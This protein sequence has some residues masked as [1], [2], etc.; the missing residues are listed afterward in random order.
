MGD[1][2]LVSKLY[3]NGVKNYLDILMP[4]LLRH[5]ALEDLRDYSTVIPKTFATET[6]IKLE[7]LTAAL[8][9]ESEFLEEIKNEKEIFDYEWFKKVSEFKYESDNVNLPK[10]LSVSEIKK[11]GNFLRKPNFM[12]DGISHTNLGTLYHKIFELLPVKKYGIT[13]LNEELK[14]LVIDGNITDEELSMINLENIFAYLTTSLY[15]ELLNSNRVYK[16]MPLTFEIPAS[17]YDKSLK[18]GNILTSGVIDLLF[19]KD[20]VYTII[21]YKTD[22]VTTLD[23]LKDMY[24]KQLDLY[25]IGIKEKMNAKYVRK[26]IYSIKLN[27]F[28]EV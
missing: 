2:K 15:D 19:V 12:N 3:L 16:E 25:E 21:D 4:C 8:I 22:N 18:S 14:K 7:V 27:K 13:T 28:I 17:Y 1:K 23:E 24:K 9:D 26:F 5:P 11:H 6:Q 10:Y 20:D